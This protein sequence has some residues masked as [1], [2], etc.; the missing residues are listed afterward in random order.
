M[1]NWTTCEGSWQPSRRSMLALGGLAM[2]SWCAPTITQAQFAEKARDVLVVIF[3]RGGM[4]GLNFLVP[5]HED[6]Y[7]RERP[8]LALSSQAT[9][10]LT[11]EWGL[12][13]AAGGIRQAWDDGQCA[14]VHACGSQD[15]SRSH[16]EAMK[17][18]E[19]GRGSNRET[20]RGGWLAQ[21]LAATG[22]AS[23]PLRALALADTLPDSLTGSPG[24]SAFRSLAEFELQGGAETRALLSRLYAQGDDQFTVAGQQTLATLDALGKL[25]ER[26]YQPRGG[27]KYPDSDFGQALRQAA[28][29]IR[30]QVGLEVVSIDRGGWDTHIAQGSTQGL[31]TNNLSDLA[32][33]IGA[34]R[35]DMGSDLDRVTIVVQTEFGRRVAENAGLG[36]DHGRASV[37]MVMSPHVRGGVHGRWPGLKP[38]QRDE[39]ADL[40]VANDYRDVIGEVIQ[41]RL[42]LQDTSGIFAGHL[43]RPL[44]LFA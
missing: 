29:L 12:H 10:K 37:A 42:G 30:A 5:R 41:R 3:L 21:L 36:T 31:F 22:G 32:A 11:D 2:M 44:G 23:H 43:V 26:G 34:F 15:G 40:I 17:A 39:N 9:L 16:F 20:D 7:F 28:M 33:G 8:S 14:L 19:T 38:S 25:D 13:P 1:S 27:A 6:D 35:Q 24:S 4:D 18:M